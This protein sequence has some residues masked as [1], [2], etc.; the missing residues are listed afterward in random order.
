MV[1]V[2]DT[3]ALISLALVDHLELLQTLYGAVYIPEAVW[4]EITVYIEPMHVLY[5]L[6]ECIRPVTGPNPFAGIMHGG[7]AEAACLYRE[8]NADYLVIDDWDA[9]LIAEANGITCIGKQETV[10]LL[11]LCVR[12]LP[13]F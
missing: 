3:G 6:Q 1:I 11:A 12:F 8:L 9:R 13:F 5:D 10:L 7:E 4:R 2:A